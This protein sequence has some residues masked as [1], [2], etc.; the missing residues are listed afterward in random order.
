MTSN[1]QRMATAPTRIRHLVVFDAPDDLKRTPQTGD[2]SAGSRIKC[3][4]RRLN[5]MSA[6]ATGWLPWGVKWKAELVLSP[7]SRR[8]A[9]RYILCCG[10]SLR[11]QEAQLF[12]SAGL[13]DAGVREG[14]ILTLVI[15]GAG[16]VW[17]EANWH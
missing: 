12:V 5:I 11:R 13:L 14:G 2:P 8:K 9:A 1:K 3:T 6:L 10:H 16:R 7:G 15:T 4:R 17:L